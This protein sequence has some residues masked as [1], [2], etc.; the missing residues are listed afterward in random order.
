EV[1][2]RCS[3]YGNNSQ[4]YGDC[5]SQ[6]KTY[7]PDKNGSCWGADN[8]QSYNKCMQSQGKRDSASLKPVA[9]TDRIPIWIKA[10][11]SCMF[12]ANVDSCLTLDPEFGL[13]AMKLEDIKSGKVVSHTLDNVAF[14]RAMRSCGL[15]SAACK[16]KFETK[17][18]NDYLFLSYFAIPKSVYAET[19]CG[20]KGYTQ[21]KITKAD[22]KT[23]Y[24]S[25]D[26]V[27]DTGQRMV[28]SVTCSKPLGGILYSA[29]GN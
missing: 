16:A 9:D 19:Y 23:V 1:R 24:V 20:N 29:I 2:G 14:T 4:A 6:Q 28:M 3:Q 7:R 15:R 5:L 12:V 11:L 22:L 25:P 27:G 21:Y 17:D 18:N 8:A 10:Q 26:A 13:A